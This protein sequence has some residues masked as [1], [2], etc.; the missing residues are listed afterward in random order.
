MVISG[1][2]DLIVTKPMH[3]KKYE[4]DAL[5]ENK[6]IAILSFLENELFIPIRV[7][8]NTPRD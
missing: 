6:N 8:N 5:A 3:S 1:I 7:C 4:A 2:L